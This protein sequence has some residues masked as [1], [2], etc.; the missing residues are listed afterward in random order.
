M[1][2]VSGAMSESSTAFS[3]YEKNNL[4]DTN[5]SVEILHINTSNQ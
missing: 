3:A 1:T 4:L 2:N 5:I